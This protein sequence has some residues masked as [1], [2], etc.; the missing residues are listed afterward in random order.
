M[1]RPTSISRYGDGRTWYKGNTHI[2]ST[3]SDGGLD[4][5]ELATAYALEG[6]DFLVRTD[7]WVASDITKD[8]FE[9]PLLW[10]DGIE[11]D[12]KDDQGSFYHVVG[13]GRFEGIER[14][15]GLT[16]ALSAIR[17]QGGLL[18]LAHPLWTGN[19]FEEAERWNFDGVEL[20]NHVC[21]WL[22]GKGD[23]LAYWQAMLQAA[24]NTLAFAA[25]DAHIRPSHPGWNGG[26]VM[27]Q[28]ETLAPD[29]I[30]ESLRTGRFYSSTGPSFERIT[31][32]GSH[33]HIAT[34]EIQF[35]RL[36]GPASLGARTGDFS[37]SLFKEA[38]F[39][40]PADWPYAYVEIEDAQGRRA[41]TNT[42][43][44]TA[45]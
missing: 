26:W 8:P 21:H 13:L 42:L 29:E 44:T 18:I 9:A 27:V 36:A 45:E 23:G 15:M 20:Y 1:S 14:E 37:G 3:A 35:A 38:S 39:E 25:D 30:R 17:E 5:T 11:L 33:V 7:H 43:L 12:G 40:I 31:C 6:Y 2:H 22:N 24:P 16:A 19:T 10:L 41:W 4:F 32:D 28:A 34:S